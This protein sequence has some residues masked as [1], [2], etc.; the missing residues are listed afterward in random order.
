MY[1]IQVQYNVEDSLCFKKSCFTLSSGWFRCSTAL[2]LRSQRRDDKYGKD[3]LRESYC[4][5]WSCLLEW[6][7][8]HQIG[9]YL[10]LA[11]VFPK[12][13]WA[14]TMNQAFSR[15]W[16]WKSNEQNMKIFALWIYIL[17]QF[18]WVFCHKDMGLFWVNVFCLFLK[19]GEKDPHKFYSIALKW[20]PFLPI[21]HLL[22]DE[23]HSRAEFLASGFGIAY[24]LGSCP[25]FYFIFSPER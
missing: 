18:G 20:S 10:R 4:K 12:V 8:T 23:P 21:A 2:L 6:L 7:G 13:F 1:I 17:N 15:Y 24:S 14:P 16:R 3:W 9:R 5:Y 22:V 11:S 19:G 25:I